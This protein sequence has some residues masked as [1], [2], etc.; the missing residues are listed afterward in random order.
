MQEERVVGLGRSL[1]DG[2]GGGVG[3]PVALADHEAIEGVVGVEL[4]R[5]QPA[6]PRGP[7]PLGDKL[8]SV[9]S[10]PAATSAS[11]ISPE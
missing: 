8:I 6:R 1:G 10:E 7:L 4:D 2:K 3:D 9:S 5:R 11:R